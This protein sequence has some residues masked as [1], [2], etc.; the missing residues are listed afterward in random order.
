MTTVNATDR[1]GGIH[2]L[3]WEPG[4]SLMECLRDNDLPVLASC[5]GTAS[6]STCHV[7]LERSVLN[8]LGERSEDELELLEDNEYF[9]AGQSRLSC[10]INHETRLDGL[11]VELAPEE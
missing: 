2:E 8:T 4:Q 3:S 9:R 11:L 7:Y 5:G 6:C 10:Q 1:D